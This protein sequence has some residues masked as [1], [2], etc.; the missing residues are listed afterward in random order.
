MLPFKS[1]LTRTLIYIP[2]IALLTFLTFPTFVLANPETSGAPV[3]ATVPPPTPSPNPATQH[4]SIPILISPANNSTLNSNSPTFIF[5]PSTDPLGINKYELWINGSFDQNIS[6]AT[7]LTI[8]TTATTALTDGLHTW[9]IKAVNNSGLGTDSATFS[10]TTDT[11]PPII[12]LTNIG[13]NTVALSSQ[14]TTT[15]PA[16]YSVTTTSKSPT[17]SGTSEPNATLTFSLT[18][19]VASYTLTTTTSTDNSFS[20]TPSIK[21]ASGSYT[22]SIS[23]SDQA[24]NSTSLPSFT[25]TLTTQLAKTPSITIP[26]PS[27]LPTLTIP[28]L[29]IPQTKLPSLPKTLTAFPLTID[30]PSFITYLPWLIIFLFILYLFIN[31]YIILYLILLIFIYLSLV[32]HHWLPILFTL[33]HLSLLYHLKKHHKTICQTNTNIV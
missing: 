27:P 5:E 24:S 14:D 23:A 13:E 28:G 10:F 9:K 19:T 16:N 7:T 33:L 6:P 11:T 8:S 12:L 21:L 29:P 26:L 32:T 25:L 3:S 22:V 2:T 1:I 18:S 17:F 4:P 20:L 15:I 30:S 31:K